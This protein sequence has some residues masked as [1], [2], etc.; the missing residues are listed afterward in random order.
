MEEEERERV[1]VGLLDDMG[2]GEVEREWV[3]TEDRDT[4]ELLEGI[5]EPDGVV[6]MEGGVEAEG[7]SVALPPPLREALTDP[8]P[9]PAASMG[10]A[11]G[12]LFVPLTQCVALTHPVVLTERGGL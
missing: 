8:P 12:G 1:E 7:K 5:R 6:D 2:E 9:H 4:L 3:L 10:V 11:V